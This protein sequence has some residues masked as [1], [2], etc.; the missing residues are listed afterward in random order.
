MKRNGIWIGLA[1]VVLALAIVSVMLGLNLVPP[2][3]EAESNGTIAGWWLVWSVIWATAVTAL[4][5]AGFLL[6]A[7]LGKVPETANR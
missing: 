1:V 5:V 6:A 4:V 7:G 3:A 2:R